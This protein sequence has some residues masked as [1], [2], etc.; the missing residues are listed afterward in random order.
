[1][2]PWQIFRSRSVTL[3]NTT[4]EPVLA[5]LLPQPYH[6]PGEVNEMAHGKRISVRN[7]ENLEEQRGLQY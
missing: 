2:A 7:A 1:M 6:S 5:T 4:A 3:I